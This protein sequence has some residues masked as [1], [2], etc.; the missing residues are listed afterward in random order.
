MPEDEGQLFTDIFVMYD[1][2]KLDLDKKTNYH[3]K[4]KSCAIV[5]E[6]EKS[7]NNNK[8]LF[9]NHSQNFSYF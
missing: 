7:N 3:M 8:H 4:S 5:N 6:D 1:K 2:K 9:Q